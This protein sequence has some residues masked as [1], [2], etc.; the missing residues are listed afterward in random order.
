MTQALR[1]R[2]ALSG[3]I[4]GCDSNVTGV[5]FVSVSTVTASFRNGTAFLAVFSSKCEHCLGNYSWK[6]VVDLYAAVPS[7]PSQVM[8]Q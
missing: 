8:V 2:S 3:D 1:L 7:D 6:P 4:Q 5:T